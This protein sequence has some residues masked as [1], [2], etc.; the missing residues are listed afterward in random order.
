[1]APGV[2]V[3]GLRVELVV[4]VVQVELLLAERE[5]RALLPERHDV[6]AKHLLV[7]GAGRHD[8]AH[9]QDEVI[10]ALNLHGRRAPVLRR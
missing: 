4:D 10:D 6:R 5:R 7:E 2:G 3:G 1:M 8:V 9:G